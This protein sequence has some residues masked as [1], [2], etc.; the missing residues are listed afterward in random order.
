MGG[1]SLCSEPV[2]Q[3]LTQSHLIFE[4]CTVSLFYSFFGAVQLIQSQSVSACTKLGIISTK[5]I[6]YVEIAFSLFLSSRS[7]V[8]AAFVRRFRHHF[9]SHNRVNP[10]TVRR[11]RWA[12]RIMYP[13]IILKCL[14]DLSLS[15]FFFFLET[16][17]EYVETN[18]CQALRFLYVTI[19]VKNESR[20]ILPLALSP[21]RY[22][23]FRTLDSVHF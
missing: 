3:T 19:F 17:N 23:F 6:L 10:V 20:L 8:S 21:S 15:L 1:R 5:V 9:C 12:P 2:G 22:S 4:S 14:R 13:A 7:Q 11:S 16:S 18:A